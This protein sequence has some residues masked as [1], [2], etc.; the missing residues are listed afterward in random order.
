MFR[1]VKALVVEDDL[2]NRE[3]LRQ[4]ITA[5]TFTARACSTLSEGLDLVDW[6]DV[7][8][9][10][11]KLPN[12][13]GTTL[14]TQWTERHKGPVVVI[15]GVVDKDLRGHLLRARAWNVLQK[16][17]ELDVLRSILQRYGEHVLECKRYQR[18]QARVDAL[19]QE[20]KKMRRLAWSL[21]VIAAAAGAGAQPLISLLTGG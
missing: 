4:M 2:D 10:D 6:A 20:L 9:L 14:L 17:F 18:L 16:P 8:V 15:S 7:L 11:L 12:G 5:M 21:A 19:E 1:D 3:M 13:Q